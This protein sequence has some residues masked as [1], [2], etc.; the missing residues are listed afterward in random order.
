MKTN[1]TKV[2]ILD[3]ENDPAARAEWHLLFASLQDTEFPLAEDPYLP[4]Q[5]VA[6]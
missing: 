6:H 5:R 3:N 1:A 4:D 2:T